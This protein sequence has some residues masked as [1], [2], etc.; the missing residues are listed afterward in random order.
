MGSRYQLA[1]FGKNMDAIFKGTSGLPGL[2]IRP[3]Y[4]T[5]KK[6]GYIPNE[7]YVDKFNP[8]GETQF[9]A[10]QKA[11]AT[12]AFG[13]DYDHPNFGINPNRLNLS[14]KDGE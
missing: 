9:E 11:A 3:H 10:N 2:T 13:R 4:S 1:G 12:D 14:I 7:F 8:K 6:S 5:E